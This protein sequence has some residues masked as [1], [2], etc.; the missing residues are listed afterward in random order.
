MSGLLQ[1][2]D[3]H[4]G[5]EIPEVVAALADLARRL[6]PEVLVVSGDITQRARACQFAAARAFI[7]ALAIPRRLVLPGNHDVPL[8]DLLSRCFRPY[9]RHRHAFGPEQPSPVQTAQWRVIGI[10]ATRRYRHI[11]GELSERQIEQVGTELRAASPRQLRVVVTHQPVCVPDRTLAHDL[12]HGHERAVRRWA[13]AGADVLMG[14]HIHLPYVEALHE[15]FEG[16]P[17]RLWCVQAG[18]AV[19][20]RVRPEAPNSVNWLG[21]LPGPAGPQCEVQRWDYDAARA[22]FGCVAT[23]RLAVDRRAGASPG[24]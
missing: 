8:F 16:L 10:D 7:E 24:M 13:A 14:G 15:R 1:V 22:G 20:R 4:F 12:V 19:S 21:W 9:A 6:Q 17:R 11:D 23:H 3:L 2:S 5:T 18:T